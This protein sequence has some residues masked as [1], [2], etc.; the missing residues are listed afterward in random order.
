MK[1]KLD[2]PPFSTQYI[3]ALYMNKQKTQRRPKA[4]HS[5]RKQLLVQD[6]VKQGSHLE[7]MRHLLYLE[8]MP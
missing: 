1:Q 4:T 6:K 7:V 3:P 5:K 8:T 2:K